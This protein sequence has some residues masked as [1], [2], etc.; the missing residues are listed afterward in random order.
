MMRL[1]SFYCNQ[2]YASE[3][4]VE[5]WEQYVSQKVPYSEMYFVFSIIFPSQMTYIC[6]LRDEEY[7][8]NGLSIHLGYME[9]MNIKV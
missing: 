6:D 4:S 8:S 9:N 7:Y 3:I 2:E 1:D 5:C